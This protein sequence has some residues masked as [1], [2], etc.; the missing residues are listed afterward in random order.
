[1]LTVFPTFSRMAVWPLAFA[2][3][4]G[5]AGHL[6][7]QAPRSSGG[8]PKAKS[9]R[10]RRPTL[11]VR[12][13]PAVSFSPARVLFVAELRGGAD[14]YEGFYC[15]AVEWDWGDGTR[16][17]ANYDCEPYEPGKSEIRRRF[18]NE[19]VFYTAGSYRVQFRLKRNDKVVAAASTTVQVRPGVRDIGLA[20]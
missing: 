18:T 12:A 19:H 4:L 8:D 15:A 16:S 7:A 20:P 2:L 6:E 5:L 9:E 14:D 10:D 13:T 17:Q 3:G 11:V 1:M